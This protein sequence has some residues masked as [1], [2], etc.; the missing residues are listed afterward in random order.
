M[1]WFITGPPKSHEI[2]SGMGIAHTD[3]A[4]NGTIFATIYNMNLTYI[5]SYNNKS[6]IFYRPQS[7]NL[8]N[9]AVKSPGLPVLFPTINYLFINVTMWFM[10]Y[11]FLLQD[12][13][14]KLISEVN[15]SIS[16]NNTNLVQRGSLHWKPQNNNILSS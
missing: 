12:N 14:Y 13:S 4:N 5:A 6:S 3:H 1:T 8:V 2:T 9:Y 10:T 15:Q 7:I 11:I 16:L